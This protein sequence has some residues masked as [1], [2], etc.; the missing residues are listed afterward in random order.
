MVIHQSDFNA[1]LSMYL[2]SGRR[3]DRVLILGASISTESPNSLKNRFQGHVCIN[4]HN[5]FKK[6]IALPKVIIYFFIDL[7]Q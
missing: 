1:I 5:Q 4:P 7:T 2:Q 6:L 3:Q